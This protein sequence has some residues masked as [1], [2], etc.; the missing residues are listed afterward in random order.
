MAYD[1]RINIMGQ[2]GLGRPVTAEREKERVYMS[3]DGLFWSKQNARWRDAL[4]SSSHRAPP[5]FQVW[6]CGT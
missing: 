5:N 6:L 4:R 2:I 1:G 3:V